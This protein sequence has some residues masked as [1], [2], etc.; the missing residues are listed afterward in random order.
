VTVQC[1]HR[2]VH[3]DAAKRVYDTYSLHKMAAGA[4]ALGRWIACA[5]ADGTSDNTLYD[6]RG[7]AVRHQ[8]HN[9]DR[10][11]FIPIRP[12][13]FTPCEAQ[14]LLTHSRMLAGV[15]KQMLDRN[16]RAGGRQIIRRLTAEDERASVLS[17]LTGSAPTNLILPRN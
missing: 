7:A 10:Y 5:L 12:G 16:H 2:G 6:D 9:E 1:P 17:I 3:S 8:H 15:Q 4:G 11:V 13:S 14:I